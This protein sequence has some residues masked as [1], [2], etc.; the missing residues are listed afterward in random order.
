MIGVS[1]HTKV[2]LSKAQKIMKFK[3]QTSLVKIADIIDDRRLES[4]YE[5]QQKRMNHNQSHSSDF[6]NSENMS[7]KFKT[8]VTP[9]MSPAL[10]PGL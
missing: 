3:R 2:Q 9:P 8:N 6:Y 4:L 7:V 1:P 5:K 10:S